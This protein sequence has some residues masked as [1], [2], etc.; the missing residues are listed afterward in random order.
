MPIAAASR[1]LAKSPRTWLVCAAALP[2]LLATLMQAVG[3]SPTELPAQ[4][5]RPALVFE[6]YLVNLG[7]ARPSP[8]VYGRFAFTNR[9]SE[10]VRITEIE[11]SCKCLMPELKQREYAPGESGEFHVQVKT[12][13]EEPGPKEYT[14]TLN[15]TDP[16]PRSVTVTFKVDLPDNQI[17]VRPAMLAFFQP[18]SQEDTKEV[19]VT[20]HSGRNFEFKEIELSRRLAGVARVEL[21]TIDTDEEGNRQFHLKV[22][23]HGNIAPGRHQGIARI[24]TNDTL[25]QWIMVPIVVDGPVDPNASQSQSMYLTRPG[26]ESTPGRRIIRVEALDSS[27]TDPPRN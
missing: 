10:T 23:A 20:D 25:Y 17:V 27:D 8:I 19:I 1:Q 2:M 14:V 9:G 11:P 21:G 13:N 5:P 7:Q 26:E 16:R 4:S 15:Y 12:P 3:Q 24:H 6:Q 18:G 22:T